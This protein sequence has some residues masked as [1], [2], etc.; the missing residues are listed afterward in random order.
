MVA[1]PEVYPFQTYLFPV[2]YNLLFLD[3]SIFYTI[4]IIILLLSLIFLGIYVFWMIRTK[5]E[6]EAEKDFYYYLTEESAAGMVIFQENKIKY[7]NKAMERLT[8]FSRKDLMSLE[9]WQIIHPESIADTTVKNWFL[10]QKTP[11]INGQFRL[12]Q[13]GK[14]EIWSELMTKQIEFLGQAAFL[15]TAIDVTN[16]HEQ[17]LK[18]L[19]ADHR[20]SLLM[21]VSTDGL[22]EYNIETNELF[23]S[24]QWK[25]MLG[26]SDDDL[27]NTL[28]VLKDL[29]HPAD[30]VIYDELERCMM[31]GEVPNQKLTCRFRS[32]DGGYLWILIRLSV[33]Y[34]EASQPVKVLGSYHDINQQKFFEEEFQK[35]IIR[36]R[37]FFDNNP[38]AILVYNPE[39]G[40]ITKCNKSACEF[41]GYSE[42]EITKLNIEE[43][44][45]SPASPI[46]GKFSKES[47][48]RLKDGQFRNVEIYENKYR[49]NGRDLVFAIIIDITDD[50]RL[51]KE[52]EKAKILAEESARQKANFL[53]GISHE[54]RTPLNSII[55]LAELLSL[56]ENMREE[57]AE[58][59]RSIKYSSRHL[60]GI[61][62]DVLD[63]SKLEEGQVVLDKD[64]LNLPNLIKNTTKAI[65]FKAR[66]KG[67]TVKISINS[68]L[69]EYVMGDEG[70]IRQILLNLLSNAIKFT[71]EGNINIYVKQVSRT[72]KHS[73]IRFSVSDTGIGIPPQKRTMIFE[74]YTQA[75]KKTYRKYGGT[76]LGLPISKRLVELLGGE[77]GVVSIEGIGSTFFFE[78]PFEVSEKAP[79]VMVQETGPKDK[80][81]K[82]LKFL[83][84]EDDPMNRF[85]ILQF[86]RKWNA[87]VE[88]A[89]NGRVAMEI[90]SKKAFDVVFMDLHMP[91]MDGFETVEKIRKGLPYVLNPDVIVI[92]LT[93]DVNDETRTMVQMAGMNDYIVKPT[94]SELLYRKIISHIS[95][96]PEE[97]K[98]ET[99]ITSSIDEGDEPEINVLK[100][101]T[102]DSLTKIFDDNSS[103]AA[104]LVKHF[105][106]NIPQVIERVKKHLK[107][108]VGEL[109]A[110][111]LHKI[112]PGFS[113]LGFSEVSVKIDHLQNQIR[114]NK[115]PQDVQRLLGEIEKDISLIMLVLEKVLQGLEENE[116]NKHEATK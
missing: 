89:E 52:L 115:K 111:A 114:S 24:S 29:I 1:A 82:G 47:R 110:Q 109:A 17:E 65:E 31:K 7:V 8:G 36:F 100:Q 44:Q 43:I 68:N 51:A 78:V 58:N 104:S 113:H 34:N 32:K 64:Y 13:K 14:E 60:L 12:L 35:S 59:I 18:M 95:T 108:N 26:Y 41:Y 46:P 106:N 30:L 39:N 86:L 98:I 5:K 40:F 103:A 10:N 92:A 102:I 45:I 99:A 93:A 22:S 53:T 88:E 23:L 4:A 81:L 77:I 101:R 49:E 20:H 83:L 42:E 48:H 57:I 28:R 11:L 9:I 112:K 54:I 63:L 16:K 21:Q 27:N 67:L 75:D 62:N 61:I 79:E 73:R 69:P 85:V 55:G 72:L 90:L 105:M 71:A 87:D 19:E 80:N 94:D 6:A 76:G 15:V 74:S 96:V 33:V 70:R 91:E 2:D 107:N 38:L 66:E 116:N 25:E 37:G 97:Q 50:K 56:N 84:V 3:A